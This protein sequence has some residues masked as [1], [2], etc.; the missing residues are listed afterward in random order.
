M[1]FARQQKLLSAMLVAVSAMGGAAVLANR[2]GPLTSGSDGA[3]LL[4]FLGVGTVAAFGVGWADAEGRWRHWAAWYATLLVLWGSMLW[5]LGLDG[6]AVAL[7]VSLGVVVHTAAYWLGGH[8]AEA[9]PAEMNRG[10]RL[11][12]LL[13]GVTLAAAYALTL[14]NDPGELGHARATAMGLC[15]AGPPLGLVAGLLARD[16]RTAGWTAATSLLLLG[17]GFGAWGALAW[18]GSWDFPVIVAFALVI[19]AAM[20]LLGAWLRSRPR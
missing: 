18:R 20:V 4:A 8:A 1:W 9:I 13:A 12:G 17:L 2:L 14:I 5:A 7:G 11:A 19:Q 6:R 10:L 15:L 3:G 16:I